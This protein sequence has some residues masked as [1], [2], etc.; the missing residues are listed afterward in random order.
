MFERGG[1]LQT[2]ASEVCDFM[3][4]SLL[5]HPIELLVIKLDDHRID[6]LDYEGKISGERGDVQRVAGGFF[7]AFQDDANKKIFHLDV[8]SR[9]DL[10]VE[11]NA[12]S[13]DGWT[14]MLQAKT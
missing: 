9:S 12:K 3:P 2:W 13:N 11:L 4:S 5:G 6:Y 8:G 7:Q 10:I 1:V 14:M